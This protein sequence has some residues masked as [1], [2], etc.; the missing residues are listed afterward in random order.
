MSIDARVQTVHL[1]EDGSGRL[2]LIDRPA[3]TGATPG[4]AGHRALSYTTAPHEVTA[5]NGLD[6]WGSANT[7]MLGDVEIA[8]RDGYTKIVF[9]DRE[10]FNR[11]VTEYHKKTRPALQG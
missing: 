9:C 1:N 7:I 4:C 10:T 3:R 6:I 2:D 11:A 8:K 5:L